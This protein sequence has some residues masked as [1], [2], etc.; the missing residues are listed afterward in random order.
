LRCWITNRCTPKPHWLTVMQVAVA[1]GAEEETMV[2]E[3]AAIMG[4]AG[5]VTGK[6][7]AAVQAVMPVAAAAVIAVRQ[8]ARA[9]L[10]GTEDPRPH[11]M[12]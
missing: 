11:H 9:R 8:A 7:P 10:R 3:V 6:K 4:A 12:A 5:A 1:M 2:A